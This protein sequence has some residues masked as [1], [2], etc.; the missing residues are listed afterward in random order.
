MKICVLGL[1]YVGAVSAAC[2]A[3]EGHEIIGVD[4]EA[5]KVDLINSGRSPIIEKDLPEI[6]QE[7]VGRGRLRATS[8]VAEAVRVSD[9]V[10]VC[11]GTPS[12]PN[13]GIDLKYIKRVCEQIGRTLATHAGAP[14][15]VMRSTMLPGTMRDV[16]IPILEKFSGKK[17]GE[18]FGLC[19]N[20]EFLREG[21]AVHDY[22]HPPKTVIGEMNRASGDRLASLYEAMPDRKSVV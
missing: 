16:V 18:E 6:I 19:I 20:P 2:L 8:D 12:Q 17:A 11:V 21:T 5:T 3:K 10:F 9:L 22:Y 13:G 4:P 1:G 15:I 14:V 7:Q